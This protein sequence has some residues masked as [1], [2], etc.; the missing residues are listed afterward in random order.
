MVIARMWAHAL[1]FAGLLAACGALTAQERVQLLRERPPQ[2]RPQLLVLG[3]GHF[4]NPGRDVINVKVDD[5]LTST[6]QAQIATAAGQLAAFHPTQVAVEWDSK[7]QQL[8]NDRYE[9]YLHGTYTLSRNEIDQLGLRVAAM[10]HL[11][12]VYAID[13]QEDPPGQ[14]SDYDFQAFAKGHGQEPVLAALTDPQRALGVIATGNQSIGAWLLA[15]NSP[16]A[17][18]DSQREY[19]DFVQIGDR[20]HQPGANWVGSWYARNLIIFNNITHITAN[21]QD[22]IL[23]IYG[24]GHAYHLR[25]FALESGGFRLVDVDQVL[26]P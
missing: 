2:A 25:R 26:K 14:E 10:L 7:D 5:V 11:P 8:L 3:S 22:R 23:V 24:Q 1:V 9:A 20:T 13:W 16:Q 6:R 12:R 15:L 4:A 17:L 21:P 18:A 19:F